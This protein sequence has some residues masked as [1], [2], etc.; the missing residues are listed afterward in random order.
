MKR[1]KKG[2]IGLFLSACKTRGDNSFYRLRS[3][4]TKAQRERILRRLAGEMGDSEEK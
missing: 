3:R 1:K 2:R 4:P